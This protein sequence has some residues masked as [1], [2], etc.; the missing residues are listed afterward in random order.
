MRERRQD[1][2]RL[3]RRVNQKE[4]NLD[5]KLDQA[6]QKERQITTKEKEVESA[7]AE[8]LNNLDRQLAELQRVANMTQ[9]E[10]KDALLQAVEHE[11]REDANRRLMLLE[12]AYKEEA[13]RRARDIVMQAIQGVTSEV[14]SDSTTSM[15]TIPNEEMKG[16][17]IGREGRNIRALE[18]ATGVDIII[19]DTPDCVTLSSF[20]PIRREIARLALT[21]LVSD[22]R[23]HPSRIEDVV[24]LAKSEIDQTMLREGER[25]SYESNVPDLHPGPDTSHGP[26]QV[27]LQLRSKRPGA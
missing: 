5:R 24:E 2:Q 22:G 14:V 16:R 3:E 26:S 27:S 20:D 1:I 23:I 9:I 11:V 21:R 6:D 13:D 8:I 17:I 7:K 18:H 19:D 12:K 10:A 25:A 4:E 15:V